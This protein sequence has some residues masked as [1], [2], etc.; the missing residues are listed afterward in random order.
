MVKNLPAMQI[1]SRRSPGEGNDIPFHDL[2][3]KKNSKQRTFKS[4]LNNFQVYNT[5]L[6]IIVTIIDPPHLFIL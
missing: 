2:V 1:G 4:T 5:V 6:L 3:T